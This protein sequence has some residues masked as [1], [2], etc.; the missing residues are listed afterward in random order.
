MVNGSGT[1]AAAADSRQQ[2]SAIAIVVIVSLDARERP[3][4]TCWI[5]RQKLS[6]VWRQDFGSFRLS[7]D[8]DTYKHLKLK[9]E[10]EKDT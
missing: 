9:F 1:I 4:T 6:S 10:I 3:R 7:G 8:K 2:R 5:S